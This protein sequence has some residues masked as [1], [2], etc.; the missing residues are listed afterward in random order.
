M[1]STASELPAAGEVAEPFHPPSPPRD[2]DELGGAAIGGPMINV[3]F[4]A[5]L[6]VRADGETGR[7]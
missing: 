2:E 5:G 6:A 1:P 7:H 3:W 4:L